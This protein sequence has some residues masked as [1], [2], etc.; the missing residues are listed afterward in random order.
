MVNPTTNNSI[1]SDPAKLSEAAE[2]LLK[3]LQTC[4]SLPPGDRSALRV[5][6]GKVLPAEHPTRQELESML[7]SVD[8]SCNQTTVSFGRK[9]CG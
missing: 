8:Y 5:A 6:V 9:W 4:L 3:A 1:S 2:V 7:E